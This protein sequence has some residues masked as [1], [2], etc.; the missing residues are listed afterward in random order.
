M[1]DP[2]ASTSSSSTAAP[3]RPTAIRAASAAYFHG[4]LKKI[5]AGE[6][7]PPCSAPAA[8]AT[9]TAAAATEPAGEEVLTTQ[10]GRTLRIKH[11]QQTFHVPHES[12]VAI[13]LLPSPVNSNSGD[14]GG[15]GLVATLFL[16]PR[17]ADDGSDGGEGLVSDELA[18]FEF[19][20]TIDLL[21]VPYRPARASHRLLGHSHDDREREGPDGPGQAAGVGRG[22]A[23]DGGGRGKVRVVEVTFAAP[24]MLSLAD[25]RRHEELWHFEQRWH[26]GVVLQPH[27]IFRRHKRLAVFDMDSTLIE[28]EVID[29]IA[30]AVGLEP[31]VA[32]IT[33]RAMNGELDFTQSLQ[34]RVGL[35]RGT[36][37][38]VLDDVK[39]ALTFTPGARTLCRALKRLGFALAVISGGFLPLATHVQ[40]Q[41]GLDHAYANQVRSHAV[42]GS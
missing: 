27:N 34:Q 5:Q 41:L 35:L 2:T 13:P 21:N 7:A 31:R 8:A 38:S 25:L 23:G 22:R 6:P 28:Q 39:A 29:E 37:V 17:S 3:A 9:A 10:D 18:V 19:V 40:H 12:S 11:S 42:Q 4:Q 1:S 16:H 24:Q 20:Q 15:G 26:V 36:P 14:G 33:A 30:R 32:A